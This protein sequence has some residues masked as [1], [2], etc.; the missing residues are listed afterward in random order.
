MLPACLSSCTR[1]PNDTVTETY[2][3][4]RLQL[5][6]PADAWSGRD[7]CTVDIFVFDNDRLQRL[8][9]YQ[10]IQASN[11]D[12][13]SAASQTGDKIIAVVANPHCGPDSWT[14]VTSLNALLSSS[15]FLQMES[16]TSVLMS[17]YCTAA[18][19][20][21]TVRSI[22][23]EPVASE[24][25]VN[26]IRCDFSDKPYRDAVLKD[27]RAYLT[28][29]NVQT[30]IFQT[31]GFLPQSVVNL[32]K[33]DSAD[34]SRFRHPEI[35]VR[36]IGQDVGSAEVRPGISFLCYPNESTEESAGSPFTRLVIEG[37]ING[38]TCYYPIPVNRSG[39]EDGRKGIGRNCRYVFDI[40][41]RST[42]AS[43]PDTPVMLEDADISFKIVPWDETDDSQVI[44]N[45]SKTE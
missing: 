34:I 38:K 18:A 30:G 2:D 20:T 3:T 6:A 19:G 11:G 8:D 16:N 15:A 1:L 26:S 29:V 22:D 17:G 25:T 35:I 13:L 24:I 9:S 23:L 14:H 32:G 10:R 12:M 40:T 37:R 42:G 5:E 27:A 21:G 36:D 33:L 4:V 41:L 43:D 31:E 28:N 45:N 7:S 44:F 39:E